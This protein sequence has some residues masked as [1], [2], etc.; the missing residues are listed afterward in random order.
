[1]SSFATQLPGCTADHVDIDHAERL[2]IEADPRFEPPLDLGSAGCRSAVVA[3][4]RFDIPASV[5]DTTKTIA[6]RDP[7][8]VG[9]GEILTLVE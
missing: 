4:A 1:M 7:A 3:C 6:G 2:R 8:P 9:D 5:P